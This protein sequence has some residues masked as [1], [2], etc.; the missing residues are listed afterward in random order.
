VRVRQDEVRMYS[1]RRDGVG[2][3]EMISAPN[4]AAFF[5]H[6]FNLTQTAVDSA[7][8]QALNAGLPVAV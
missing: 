8:P 3:N 5:L 4:R 6:Y 2:T 1:G 7:A